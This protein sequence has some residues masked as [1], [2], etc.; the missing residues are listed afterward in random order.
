MQDV[1]V[2]HVLRGIH[3]PLVQG[4]EVIR[5]LERGFHVSSGESGDG[6]ATVF[7]PF[8]FLVIRPFAHAS[9]HADSVAFADFLDFLAEFFVILLRFR[10]LFGHRI[11]DF[12]FLG[13]HGMSV[14]I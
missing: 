7:L 10:F 4:F 8:D 13:C 3:D 5:G 14:V 12:L 2:R 9:E 1:R 6:D 11:F